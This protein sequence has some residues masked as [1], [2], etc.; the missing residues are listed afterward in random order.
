MSKRKRPTRS[1]KIELAT[2]KPRNM[3]LQAAALGQVKLGTAKHEK[4]KG[5]KRR[6][7]KVALLKAQTLSQLD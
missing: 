2:P 1:I 4:T 6:A 3:V 5:A 7:E